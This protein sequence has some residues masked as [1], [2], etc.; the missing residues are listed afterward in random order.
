VTLF[1]DEDEVPD[2][3]FEHLP[4]PSTDVELNRVVAWFKA[5]SNLAIEFGQA[6]RESIDAV[7]DTPNTGRWDLEQCDRVEKS[8]LGFKVENVVRGNW[9]LPLG[10]HGMDYSI[11]G[12]DVDCKWSKN[13]GGWQIPMEAVDHICL[14]VWS[15]E[16]TNEL[17]VGLLRTHDE[18]LVGGNQDKKRNIQSPHGRSRIRWIVDRGSH[19]PPN[20]LLHLTPDDRAAILSQR[21]GEARAAELFRRCEGVVIPRHTVD[22]IGQQTDSAR[23]ARAVRSQLKEAGWEI[24][25]G[26]WISDRRRAQELGGPIPKPGE[27]VS[28]RSDGSSQRRR[29]GHVELS[30][31]DS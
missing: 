25:N 10:Q 22:A 28:L 12:V 7:I 11:D 2:G 29:L 9:D 21:G 27:W 1:G 30:E 26:T 5:H 4:D 31:D 3:P 17:A 20:F 14:L 15:S 19:L 18:I 16:K 13:F 8:Y 24:L 6:I 23:R